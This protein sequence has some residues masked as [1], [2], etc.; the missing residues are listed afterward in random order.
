[1]HSSDVTSN[2]DATAQ[3]YNDLRQDVVDLQTRRIAIPISN[4][5]AIYSQRAQLPL[6]KTAGALTLSMIEVKLSD[7]SP[8]TELA[9][10]LKYANDTFDGGFA[11]A[12]LIAALDTTNGAM[13]KTTGFSSIASG[14]YIYIQFDASPHTDIKDLLITLY[15]TYDSP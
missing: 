6:F 5:Q 4:P 3:Q 7:N 8:T 9:A 10:D 11:N 14:K 15:F 1:M 2:T 12:T 13:S